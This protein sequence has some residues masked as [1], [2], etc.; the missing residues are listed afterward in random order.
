MIQGW[1]DGI[2]GMKIGGVREITI[3]SVL[4][5]GDQ[6]QGKIPA[7]SPLKFVVMLIEKPEEIE[8]SEELESLYGEL[9][10]YSN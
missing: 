10:G 3:P 6:E 8:I 9:Y 7:N 2:V 4:A 5:Y 1:L